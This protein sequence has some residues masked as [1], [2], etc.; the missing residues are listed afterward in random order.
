M[1]LAASLSIKACAGPPCNS[2][3]QW[4]GIAVKPYCEHED[5]I[6]LGVN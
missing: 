4:P 5:C 1:L 3:G 2:I 6:L